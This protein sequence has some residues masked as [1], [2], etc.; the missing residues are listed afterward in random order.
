MPFYI[1][2]LLLAFQSPDERSP[3]PLAPSIPVLSKEEYQQIDAVI[4]RFVKFDIG[5]LKGPEGKQ[6]LE[7]LNRLGPE[8]IFSL[9]DGFNRAA[10][11][12]LS[13]PVVY[14]GRKIALILSAS[15]DVDLLSFAKEN[16]G[17]GV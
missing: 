11:K 6:A 15:N 4:E 16:I 17:A 14:M 13:C 3:H 2:L 8:A 1:L 12:E 5:G 7:D 9:I 10:Q